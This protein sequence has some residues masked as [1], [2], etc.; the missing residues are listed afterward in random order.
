M[1]FVLLPLFVLLIQA[2]AWADSQLACLFDNH[3]AAIALTEYTYKDDQ[4]GGDIVRGSGFIIRSDGHILTAAHVLRPL[5]EHVKIVEESV[6]VRLGSATAEAIPAIIIRRDAESDTALLKIEARDQRWPTLPIGKSAGLNVGTLLTALGYPGS[7]LAIVPAAPIS[8]RN[9]LVSGVLKPW[10]QTALALNPGNS[11]GPVFG[12][13]GTVVGVAI[14]M[15]EDNAQLISYVVPIQYAQPLLAQAG[16][17]LSVAGPCGDIPSC[18]LEAHGLDHYGVSEIIGRW[19]DW[20]GGGYNRPAYC[21]DLLGS[22]KAQFPNSNFTKI[23]DDENSRDTGFRHFEY[24][25]YCEFNRQE[26]PIWR[27]AKDVNCIP[28]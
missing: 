3:A 17:A 5:F 19:S 11:G 7:D 13:L 28:P 6:K 8:S 1:R 26:G 10:W 15:R 27:D 2:N 9:S 22:L 24:R 16:V 14:A 21:N 18:R 4:K 23:R 25:Y 12:P 20:R